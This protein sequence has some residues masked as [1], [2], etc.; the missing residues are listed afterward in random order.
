M[1]QGEYKR[2]GSKMIGIPALLGGGTVTP[3]LLVGALGALVVTN[4]ITGYYAFD[5]GQ[6]DILVKNQKEDLARAGRI[7][8]QQ[9]DHTAKVREAERQM[10]DNIAALATDYQ[11]K[12]QEQKR[13]NDS[14]RA[15]VLSGKRKLF[16]PVVC[17]E[18]TVGVGVSPAPGTTGGS[19][20]Q[21]RAELPA[22]FADAVLDVGRDANE[23]TRQLGLAQKVIADYYKECGP[24]PPKK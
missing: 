23:V 14:L 8:T 18:R 2:E 17:P 16:A 6:N 5:F 21:T 11:T 13:E 10:Q 22:A 12:L 24:Q 4:G 7:I 15:D 19:D 3:W 20:G 1:D 9:K